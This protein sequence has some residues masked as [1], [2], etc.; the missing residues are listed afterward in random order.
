MYDV[1]RPESAKK[2]AHWYEHFEK[3]HGDLDNPP[4]A[5]V[6]GN[7]VDL[8]PNQK[9]KRRAEAKAAVCKFIEWAN[10]RPGRRHRSVATLTYTEISCKQDE[11]VA[12]RVARDSLVAKMIEWSN[13]GQASGRGRAD[14]VHVARNAK[15]TGGSGCCGVH[16][17]LDA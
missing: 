9:D 11:A 3:H 10:N 13:A 4:P 2:L 6:L 17:S 16:V 12:F 14:T 8:V 15:N 5:I 7:K 1:G